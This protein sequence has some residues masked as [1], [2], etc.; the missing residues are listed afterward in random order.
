MEIYALCET[1]REDA[2]LQFLRKNKVENNW[3]VT[4]VVSDCMDQ[5]LDCMVQENLCKTICSPGTEINR[6]IKISVYP[7]ISRTTLYQMQVGMDT[8]YL[9]AWLK[10]DFEQGRHAVILTKGLDPFTGN[11]PSAYRQMILGYIRSLV[12]MGVVFAGDG[13]KIETEKPIYVP[14]F[15]GNLLLA[16]TLRNIPDGGQLKLPKD[17]VITPLAREYMKEHGIHFT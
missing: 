14:E 3:P 1:G 13:T 5:T 9:P 11:E 17:V 16:K 15:S 2:F 7:S 8:E 4:A 10:A 6:E 12:G